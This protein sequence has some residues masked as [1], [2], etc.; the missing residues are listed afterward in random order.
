[1]RI[2]GGWFSG[3]LGEVTGAEAPR[4]MTTLGMG[5]WGFVF[6]SSHIRLFC[7]STATGVVVSASSS[8]SISQSS[9]TT[10]IF[11]FFVEYAAAELEAK[12]PLAD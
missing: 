7:S 1:M 11:G 2:G 3:R 4:D 5:F 9:R 6:A 8:S 10:G 12:G